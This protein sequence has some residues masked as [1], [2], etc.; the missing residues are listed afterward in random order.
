MSQGVKPSLI[1][2]L[3]KQQLAIRKVNI[4]YESGVKIAVF[5][6]EMLPYAEPNLTVVILE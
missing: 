5:N 2:S 6:Q 4:P 1:P 3:I